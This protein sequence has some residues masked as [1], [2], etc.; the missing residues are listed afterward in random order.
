MA[1]GVSLGKRLSDGIVE[2]RAEKQWDYADESSRAM[3]KLG[4]A[5]RVIVESGNGIVWQSAIW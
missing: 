3:A 1:R 4:A 5:V 2:R